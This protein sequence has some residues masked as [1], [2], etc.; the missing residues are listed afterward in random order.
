MKYNISS[1][2]IKSILLI[3]IK[4]ERNR[5]LF[6]KSKKK[7]IVKLFLLHQ[8]VSSYEKGHKR[9]WV[10]EKFSE[11]SRLM[12]GAS[13]NLVPVLKM[14]DPQAFFKFTRMS[15]ETFDLLLEKVGPKIAP[16]KGVRQPI[17]ERERLEIVIHYLSTGDLISSSSWLFRVSEAATHN[18]ITLVC[19]AIWEVLRP[20]VFEQP[21]ESMWRRVAQDF[22]DQWHFSHAI[23]ALDGQLVQIEVQI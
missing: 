14:S 3:L 6:E 23:G 15:P 4:R 12:F 13:K 10:T 11:E 18:F 20:I 2:C 16:C 19:D 8:K 22:E 5:G 1:D 21:S 17:L 7:L 9:L